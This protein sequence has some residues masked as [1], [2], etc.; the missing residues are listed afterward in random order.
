VPEAS[1]RMNRSNE[2]VV[3]MDA[4]HISICKY[5]SK[6]D[7]MLIRVLARL[8]CEVAAI[9]TQSQA[10]EREDRLQHLFESVPA[11][12]TEDLARS[13]VYSILGL[14]KSVRRK[15]E[16]YCGWPA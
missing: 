5:D 8:C 15:S 11:L 4:D 16:F 14:L 9:G 12:P 2:T 3:A 6:Q 10:Q 13:D 7:P 1:A